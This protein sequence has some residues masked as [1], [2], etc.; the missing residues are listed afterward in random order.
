MQ[1][2]LG[3]AFAVFAAMAPPQIVLAADLNDLAT[4]TERFLKQGNT[5]EAMERLDR[6]VD[7]VWESSPMMIGR[8][9]FVESATG[10]GLFVPRAAGNTFKQGEKMLVY[11]EPAAFGYGRSGAGSYTIG[12]DVGLELKDSAGEKIYSNPTFGEVAQPARYKN[13]E[14]FLDMT[15]NFAGLSIGDYIADVTLNDQNS[16]KSASFSLSFTI[17]P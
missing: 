3:V 7:I 13:R 12:F 16:K 6:M 9:A 17:E 1:R 10:Y 11:V 2:I 4:E 14:F 5:E 15:F 8:V